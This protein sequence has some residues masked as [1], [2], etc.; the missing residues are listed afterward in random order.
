[1]VVTNE[2]LWK[3]AKEEP[4]ATAIKRRKW[5]WIEHTLRKE[6]SAIE[7]QALNWNP[8][9]QRRRGRSRTWR[10]P[11]E[12]EARKAGKIQRDVKSLAGN[13]VR[14]RCSKME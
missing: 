2:Y 1:M 9:G 14:W 4:V 6:Q 10:R 8:Q 3:L 7:R 11:V 5:K 13:R 12:E